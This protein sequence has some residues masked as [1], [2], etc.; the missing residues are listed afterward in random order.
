MQDSTTWLVSTDG[1]INEHNI[2]IE[3]NQ[4]VNDCE[5]TVTSSLAFTLSA[6][7]YDVWLPNYRGTGYSNG[8]VL[9]DSIYDT[10]YWEFTFTELALYDVRAV[11]EYILRKTLQSSVGYIGHSL[12]STTMFILLSLMP[13]FERYVK[14]FIAFAPFVFM[15]NMRSNL[16]IV[17]NFESNLR[18]IP[19]AVGIPESI[20]QLIGTRLPIYVS[21]TGSTFSTWIYAHVSQLIRTGRF[22]LFDYGIQQNKERYGRSVPPD[23]PLNHILSKN[24]ALFYGLNDLVANI[25]DVLTLINRLNVK[26]LDNYLV[27][28]PKWTHH[29]FNVGVHQGQYVNKRVLKLLKP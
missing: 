13:E 27:A 20:R 29:D 1:R 18:N 24:I 25:T 11:V 8:H 16:R 26:L 9:Y 17:E 4:I 12:G 7:G 21:H 5:L 2:Y 3:N 6:C 23:Y 10:K 19:R 15:S 14:P 22:A 28:H